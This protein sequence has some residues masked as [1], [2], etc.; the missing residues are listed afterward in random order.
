M[1]LL[2]SRINLYLWT[3]IGREY[4]ITFSAINIVENRNNLNDIF[5]NPKNKKEIHYAFSIKNVA[6]TS[7]NLE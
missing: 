1:L 7:L 6:T 3:R 4:V 2:L 5:A